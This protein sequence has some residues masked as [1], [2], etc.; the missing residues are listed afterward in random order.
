MR[1]VIGLQYAE[2]LPG[3]DVWAAPVFAGVMEGAQ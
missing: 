2:S 1:Q 3:G